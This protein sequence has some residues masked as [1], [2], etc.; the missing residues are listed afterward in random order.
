[1]KAMSSLKISFILLLTACGGTSVKTNTVA[2]SPTVPSQ[3]KNTIVKLRAKD[4]GNVSSIDFSVLLPPNTKT[5]LLDYNGSVQIRGSIQAKENIICLKGS[6]KSFD[7]N[8]QLSVGNITTNNCSIN[9]H[10]FNITIVLSRGQELKSTY[11]IKGIVME[12]LSS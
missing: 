9:N 7:C 2:T 6:T 11:D 10:P 1:M 3:P 4:K 8:A 5:N 12:P